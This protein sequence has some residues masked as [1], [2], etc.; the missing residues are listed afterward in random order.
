MVM[1]C[2]RSA[3]RPSVRFARLDLAAAGNVRGTFQGCEL[4]LHHR[5]GIIEQ[6]ANQ[7]G[8]SIVH[9]T[10][11]VKAEEIDGGGVAGRS[12]QSGLEIAGLFPVF[13]CRLGGDVVPRG[14]ALG[15]AGD[16]DLGD[17][18]IH[19]VGRRH[20]Q[21]VLMISP[22]VSRTLTTRSWTSSP[23]LGGTRVVDGQPL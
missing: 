16:S 14:T 19:I 6:P 7:G 15:N 12:C 18:V 5:L 11:G 1:P 9:R 4:I 22:I 10:A 8:L 23:G 20:T 3:L 21:P 17:N 2:S 13:H